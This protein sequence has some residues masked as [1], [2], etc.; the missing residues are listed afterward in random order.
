MVLADIFCRDYSLYSFYIS[1]LLPESCG[2]AAV[3]GPREIIAHCYILFPSINV[4]FPLEVFNTWIE[5]WHLLGYSEREIND[6]IF[7]LLEGHV[8]FCEPNVF[9]K[10]I[11]TVWKFELLCY[12]MYLL[13]LIHYYFE[14]L[15][16]IWHLT[17]KVFSISQASF[18]FSLIW[19]HR[20]C[21]LS[22][23]LLTTVFN[24][25]TSKFCK[26]SI[27]VPCRCTSNWSK[28]VK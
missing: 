14:W 23:E 6:T 4:T 15:Q 28:Y 18:G 10:W 25:E 20:G 11:T 7:S 16:F 27:I 19:R 8:Y 12:A 17:E 22:A 5:L 24:L 3:P 1:S 2:C 21:C 9:R 13:R 26:R